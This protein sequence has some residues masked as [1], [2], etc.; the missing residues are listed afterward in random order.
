[1]NWYPH[2]IGD[3]K[4]ATAHLSNNEDLAYR[5][6]IEM[7]YDTEQNIPLDTHWV[8]RR[9]RMGLDVVETI[10]KEFFIVSENGYEHVRCDYEIA[11][12]HRK[13]D[14][15]RA[16]GK[17]GGRR[18]ATPAIGNNPA[19]NHP[20]AQG[21]PSAN[22]ELTKPLAIQEPRTKN[23]EPVI[24]EPKGSSSTSLPPCPQ[25]KLLELFSQ[26]CPTLPQPRPE[27]W[28]KGKNG[29]TMSARWKWVLTAIK[30]DGKRYAETPDEAIEWF[31]RYFGY[32]AS[33]DFLMGKTTD[34]QADLGWLMK[35]ENF[36]KV[37]NK[38]YK[39][40]DEK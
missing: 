11:E 40:K 27:L 33:R 10:L 26:H 14:I 13:G 35:A 20:L 2:H 9:L 39:N 30:N 16:N 5:R 23:Q 36:E 12:F 21:L 7:Y 6:L 17:K 32:I 31:D 38:N 22:P 8:S 24:K 37:L 19:G 18:K 3:Y 15:A 34:W 28:I 4:A 25:K 1:M 29:Q